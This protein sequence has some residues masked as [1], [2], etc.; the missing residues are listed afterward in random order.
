MG[1]DIYLCPRYL[2]HNVPLLSL[3]TVLF[4]IDVLLSPTKIRKCIVCVDMLCLSTNQPTV[5]HP[6]NERASSHH[7]GLQV[8]ITC[9]FMGKPMY[10]SLQQ[11]ILTYLSLIFIYFL[12]NIIIIHLYHYR[13]NY[14]RII[15]SQ[16]LV[17]S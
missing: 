7:D 4:D 9:A 11:M 1:A 10:L 15:I 8:V 5:A 17:G 13:Y 14:R 16:S 12:K 2:I 3:V 6:I